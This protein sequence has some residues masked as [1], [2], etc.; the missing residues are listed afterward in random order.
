MKK[1]YS[2]FKLM[3]DMVKIVS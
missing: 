3:G 2:L 1:N